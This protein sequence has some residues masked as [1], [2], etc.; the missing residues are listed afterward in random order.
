LQSDVNQRIIEKIEK[1]P[2]EPRVKVFLKIALGHELDHFSEAL[3]RYGGDYE[4]EIMRAVREKK[5]GQ[6]ESPRDVD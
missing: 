6:R 2:F 5:Q 1:G 4:R 3:W